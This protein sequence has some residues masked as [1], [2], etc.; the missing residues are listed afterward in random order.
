MNNI[1]W[2][3]DPDCIMARH[4]KTKLTE[5]EIK[6]LSHG[7]KLSG[8]SYML[9]DNISELTNDEWKLL[10]ICRGGFKRHSA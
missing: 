6:L 1:L 10:D 5:S 9:S 4:K 8:G 3:N 7:I 2:N